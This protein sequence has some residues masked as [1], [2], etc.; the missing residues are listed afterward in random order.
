MS[1]QR[2]R[3]DGHREQGVFIPR[4][5]LIGVAIVVIAAM[6]ATLAAVAPAVGNPV[7]VFVAVA[8]LLYGLFG[9]RRKDGHR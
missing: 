1:V 5:V 2:T 4:R 9:S 6:A 8:G 7:G 3:D